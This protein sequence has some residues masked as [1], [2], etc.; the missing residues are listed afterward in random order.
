MV[1]VDPFGNSF[2]IYNSNEAINKLSNWKKNLPWITPYY[3]IK[4]NPIKPLI[5]DL[6]NNGINFDCAS[7]G[8]INN[9]FIP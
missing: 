4:S 2:L 5:Q 6:V 9:L 7:K 3:A 8:V 1:K